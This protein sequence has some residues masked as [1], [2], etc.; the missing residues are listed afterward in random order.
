MSYSHHYFPGSPYK[1]F[2]DYAILYLQEN[3]T[4]QDL[5]QKWWVDENKR[6]ERC[7]VSLIKL[8]VIRLRLIVGT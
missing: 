2:V 1:G 5:K 7:A 6:D 8:T 4:L 3:G